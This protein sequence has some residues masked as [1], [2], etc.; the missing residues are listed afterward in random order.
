MGHREGEIEGVKSGVERDM[1]RGR[2]GESGRVG[3]KESE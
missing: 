3:Q 2:E 1:D